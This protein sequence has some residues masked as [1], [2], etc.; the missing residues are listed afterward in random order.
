MKLSEHN[1]ES[2]PLVIGVDTSNYTTSLA[3]LDINGKLIANLKRPLAVAQGERGLRQSDAVFSHV[4]NFPSLTDEAKDFFLGR[5]IAAVG[6]STQPRLQEGS[7]M[8][9]FLTGQAFASSMALAAQAPLYTF[10]HQCGHMMAVLYSSEREVWSQAPFCA[11]HV[12][13]GTTE[14]LRVSALPD[15]AGFVT[16]LVGGTKDLN[17]GQIIDRIGVYMGLSFPCGMEMEKLALSFQGKVPR[18]RM[19]IDNLFAN[20]SGLENITKKMYDDTKDK[21]LC[22]AFVFRVIA[23]TMEELCRQYLEKFGDMPV[24][25]AG[26]VMSNK[27]IR[28][29]LEN[30]FVSAFAEPELSRDNAVGIAELARRKFLRV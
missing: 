13:G 5:N 18:R 9:C 27:I 26:G 8:P 7:Y 30:A 20:L 16:E 21:S 1:A 11:F 22:S 25:F 6:V 3:I 4:K 10:S 17:A 15:Q 2:T 19:K 29:R 14:V 12:S 28:T 24:V 23:D